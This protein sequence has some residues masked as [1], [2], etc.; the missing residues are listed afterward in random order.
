MKNWRTNP[1]DRGSVTTGRR[2]TLAPYLA[3]DIEFRV[4]QLL[5]RLRRWI[6]RKLIGRPLRRGA[7][8][9]EFPK[10]TAS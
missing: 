6:I 2:R 7:Q 9:N 4:K 3:A 10:E 8:W 5:E 1:N